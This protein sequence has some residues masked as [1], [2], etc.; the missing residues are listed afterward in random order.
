MWTGIAGLLLV[1]APL[2]ASQAAPN[3]NA[4]NESSDNGTF[5]D[6]SFGN[7]TNASANETGGENATFAGNDSETNAT[8]TGEDRATIEASALEPQ[9]CDDSV[10]HLRVAGIDEHWKAPG[11]VDLVFEA[12]PPETNASGNSSNASAEAGGAG[13]NGTGNDTGNETGNETGN[14]TVD[15]LEVQVKLTGFGNR[16]AF[17]NTS[18]HTDLNLSSASAPDDHGV[19]GELSLHAGPCHGE[20]PAGGNATGLDDR[21][22]FGNDTNTTEDPNVSDGFGNEGASNDTGL[23]E[24]VGLGDNDTLGN[25]TDTEDPF[26][27][28]TDDVGLGNEDTGLGNVSN[29]TGEAGGD[30]ANESGLSG[31]ETAPA[32]VP[33]AFALLALLGVAALVSRRR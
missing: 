28:E 31:N 5:G 13:V 33:W 10:W 32:P 27:N 22:A 30:V 26:A 14:A 19:G 11:W 17:Y 21:D 12:P 6:D 3:G 24:D 16:T 25:E 18:A 7:D 1:L 20:T 29:E 8:A 4:T 23:D 15:E 9:E 2:A